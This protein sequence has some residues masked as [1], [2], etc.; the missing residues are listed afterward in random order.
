MRDH[1]K[2]PVLPVLAACVSLRA[3]R[4]SGATAGSGSGSECLC[5]IN[6]NEAVEIIHVDIIS[7]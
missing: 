3:S 5:G 7:Q 2:Q 1:P 4:S 6:G